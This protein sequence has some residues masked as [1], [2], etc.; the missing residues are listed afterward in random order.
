V[1]SGSFSDRVESHVV[2]AAPVG[3]LFFDRPHAKN[4]WA[5]SVA[6]FTGGPPSLSTRGP[7]RDGNICRRT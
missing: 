6:G 3:Q 1:S 4:R 2:A 5:T 7:N